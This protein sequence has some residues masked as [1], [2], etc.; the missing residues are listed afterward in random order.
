VR[1]SIGGLDCEVLYAG[2]QPQYAG[3]DQV[4]ARLPQ[5]ASGRLEVALTVDGREANRVVITLK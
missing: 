2:P 1:L 4:N 3:L 5:A